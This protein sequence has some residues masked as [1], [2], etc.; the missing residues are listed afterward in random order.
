[1]YTLP[2]PITDFDEIRLT[3]VGGMNSDYLNHYTFNVNDIIF[4][5]NNNEKVQTMGSV[6]SITAYEYNNKSRYRIWW[7]KQYPPTGNTFN[8]AVDVEN[9]HWLYLL[10]IEGIKYAA[11]PIDEDINTAVTETIQTLN[12]EGEN[13]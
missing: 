9:G 2:K 12:M 6:I 7:N 5:Y 10:K 13:E 8:Y 1:M 4:L 3:V 11:I